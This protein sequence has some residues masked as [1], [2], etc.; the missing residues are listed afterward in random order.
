MQVSMINYFLILRANQIQA[1]W[2]IEHGTQFSAEWVAEFLFGKGTSMTTP[3][4]WCTA[5]KVQW[6]SINNY[7]QNASTHYVRLNPLLVKIQ[8][9]FC[10]ARKVQI[11]P[12]SGLLWEWN[13]GHVN[14]VNNVHVLL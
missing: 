9:E 6:V 3:F 13:L 1:S 5:Q 11:V 4:I 12:C 2:S 8:E 10:S 7:V 14:T